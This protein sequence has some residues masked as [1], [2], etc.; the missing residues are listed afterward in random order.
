MVLLAT[1]VAALL[2]SAIESLWIRV[3]LLRV[4]LGLRRQLPR[5]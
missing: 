2:G 3:K 5:A 1:F 4:L